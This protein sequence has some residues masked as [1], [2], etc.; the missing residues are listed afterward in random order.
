MTKE[1]LQEDIM[2]TEWL[3]LISIEVYQDQEE[4]VPVLRRGMGEVHYSKNHTH[5]RVENVPD[6]E[7]FIEP[8]LGAPY[9][10][11]GFIQGLDGPYLF[12]RLWFIAGPSS[13]GDTEKSYYLFGDRNPLH[14]KIVVEAPRL[15]LMPAPKPG[16]SRDKPVR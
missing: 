2:N 7:K 11:M 1:R 4:P 3:N 15:D 16:R 8:V 5:L 13:R 14:Q 10:V 9:M 12:H 6:L